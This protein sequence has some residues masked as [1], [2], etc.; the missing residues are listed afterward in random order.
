M[1]PQ[2]GVPFLSQLEHKI[3]RKP[4]PITPHLFIEAFGGYT[5]QRGQIGIEQHLVIPGWTARYV[6][7]EWKVPFFFMVVF[8]GP[9][10]FAYL[11]PAPC[12]CWVA[13]F[14]HFPR[15]MHIEQLQPGTCPG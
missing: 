4:F 6:Q 11:E 8:S 7:W 1:R 15:S 13:F 3:F 14:P 10:V 12:Y 2:S 5:I 9:S